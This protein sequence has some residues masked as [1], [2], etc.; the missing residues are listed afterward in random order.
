MNPCLLTLCYIKCPSVESQM[1][2][3]GTVETEFTSLK[4]LLDEKHKGK[5]ATP[6]GNGQGEC[7]WSYLSATFPFRSKNQQSTMGAS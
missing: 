4:Q 1:F 5:D 2:S 3:D 7:E 6:S